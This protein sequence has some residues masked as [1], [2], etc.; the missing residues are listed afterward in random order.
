M[1]KQD[2]S[3]KKKKAGKKK[4]EKIIEEAKAALAEKPQVA[5]I[6]ADHKWSKERIEGCT[7]EDWALA[8]RC[9]ELREEGE[10]WWSIARALELE[11]AGD[12]ATTGK[13]GASRARNVYKA[14]F[15]AFP[16]TFRTG[17]QKYGGERNER[18]KELRK[19][20]VAESRAAAKA[21]KSVITAE[22]PDEEVAGM[23]RG[24]RIR[25]WVQN[26]TVSPEGFE[27]EAC[28][29]PKAPIYVIG[30]GDDRV[31]EFREEHRKAPMDV[32]WMPA[33][34]RTVRLSA[35]FSVR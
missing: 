16:R 2:K 33:H 25:W 26:D 14:G 11:G 32:R 1:S 35:I 30:E 31:I 12:S 7:D 23:L 21:G 5:T 15:G 29:H 27:M 34:I 3:I 24:R 19:A 13:K 18:V 8:V 17:Q 22:V 20:K 9:R 6:P 28:V 10:P 4:A